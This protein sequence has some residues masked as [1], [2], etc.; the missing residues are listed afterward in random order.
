MPG[1][2]MGHG[3]FR[4]GVAW[5]G[6]AAERTGQRQLVVMTPFIEDVLVGAVVPH[7]LCP[8]IADNAPTGGKPAR[9]TG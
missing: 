8:A 7:V 4:A 6:V 1:L 2:A 5:A 9:L 3:V